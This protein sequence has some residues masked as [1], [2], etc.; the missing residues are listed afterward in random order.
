MLVDPAATTPL[1]ALTPASAADTSTPVASAATSAT[2]SAAV[3]VLT[4][5]MVG[6]PKDLPGLCISLL[7]ALTLGSGIISAASFEQPDPESHPDNNYGSC[8][9]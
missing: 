8:L 9:C 7:D 3:V 6:W 5:S 4:A 2:T 1:A